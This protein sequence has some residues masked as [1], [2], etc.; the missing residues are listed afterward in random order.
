MR[1][2]IGLIQVAVLF[3][4]RDMGTRKTR[5]FL[6]ILAIVVSVSTLVALRT[7]GVG[8]HAEV[9]K[10]LRGL[11]SADLILL[12][13][14]INIPESI[15]GIVKQVPGVKSVAP[16]IFIT[17]KV[18][19]SRCYLAG[20]RMEDL[21]SF[22]NLTVT[23]GR[24]PYPNETD[25]ILVDESIY[26]DNRVFLGKYLPVKALYISSRVEYLKVIGVS[27]S[28]LGIRGASLFS[29]AALP[30][31]KLQEMISRKGYVSHILVKIEEGYSLDTVRN[32]LKKIFP[33]ANIVQQKD[34]FEAIMKVLKV[35]ESVLMAITLIGLL[36][37]ALG[38]MNTMTMTAREHIREIGIMKAVGADSTHILVIFL[39][40]AF[41]MSVIGGIL[42]IIVGYIEAHFVKLLLLKMGLMMDIPIFFVPEIGALGLFVAISISLLSAFYPSWSAAKIRPLEALRYE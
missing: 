31:E 32:E 33:E 36:V 20:V 14:E 10:Q 22:F 6:T 17:G 26:L 1:R 40:E 12:S 29:G 23:K 28:F 34:I 35:I 8:M 30:L 13:E 38:V 41:L 21:R 19:I 39:T 18:G 4:A 3:S 2:A 5:T 27:S 15:V 16:V 42:G 24:L 11:I 9:E 37:A 7:V 25:F